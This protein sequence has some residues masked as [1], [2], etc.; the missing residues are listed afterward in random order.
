MITTEVTSA[1]VFYS[2]DPATRKLVLSALRLEF[3]EGDMKE[4]GGRSNS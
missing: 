1:D 2:A 4:I 3:G